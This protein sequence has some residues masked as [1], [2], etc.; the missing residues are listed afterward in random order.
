[1]RQFAKVLMGNSRSDKFINLQSNRKA[2]HKTYVEGSIKMSTLLK[3][4]R[5]V[6]HFGVISTFVDTL[7]SKI[8]PSIPV[9]GECPPDYINWSDSP[10][11]WECW[12]FT[13]NCGPNKCVQVFTRTYYYEGG[14]RCEQLY[15]ICNYTTC[16][17]PSQC[18]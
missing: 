14:G 5:L 6:Q 9:A 4:D 18:G 13:Q 16:D 11:T 15:K 17:Y 3:I 10:S 7:A 8:L 2:S 1:M 12:E